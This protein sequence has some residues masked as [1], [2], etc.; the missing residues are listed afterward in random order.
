MIRKYI[1]KIDTNI[2]SAMIQMKTVGKKCL[3][4]CDSEN[5]LLGSLSDGDL[6]R[7]MLSGKTFKSKIKSII[8][9]RP[10][11]IFEEKKNNSKIK[12]YFVN[13][14]L[15]LIPIVNKNRQIVKILEWNN[16]FK[17]KKKIKLFNNLNKYN[18]KIVIMAGGLGKRLRPLTNLLPKPLIPIN[19]KTAI[20]HI[21]DFF[22]NYGLN[23][24]YI[25]INYKAKLLELYFN[26][27][28]KKKN[29]IFIRENKPLGTVGSLKKIKS[30]SDFILTNCDVIHKIN[31]EKF[32]KFHKK[33]N[34]DLSLVAATKK[35]SIPY[36]ICEV[37]KNNL[38]KINEKPSF[39]TFINSGFYI[40]SNRLIKLIPHNKEYNVTELIND[41]LIK[42]YKIGVFKI[43][44]SQ[45]YDIGV[46]KALGQSVK[47]FK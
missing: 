9:Y 40:I 41:A 27:L 46:W 8:N 7:A 45:W 43:K 6:R 17:T 30:N 12:N 5:Q 36:G 13:Y 2:K 32:I 44:S 16:F 31:L 18:F 20:E 23:K 24:F 14:K 26:Q 21:L 28:L 19:N 10:K 47:N 25:T 39:D 37:K 35:Y 4:I 11:Y 29:I 34:Y 38:L 3:F 42:K 1:I 15:D 22:K 33:N